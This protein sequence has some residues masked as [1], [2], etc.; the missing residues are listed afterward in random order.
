M[1]KKGLHEESGFENLPCDLDFF[2]KG[3]QTQ[4]SKITLNG[5]Q[6]KLNA[7]SVKH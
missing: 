3:T 7:K 6:F 4:S 5:I 1:K 2:D